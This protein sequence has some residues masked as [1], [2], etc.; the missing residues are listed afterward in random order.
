[1][2]L[3]EYIDI[4]H[5]GSQIRFAEFLGVNAQQVCLWSRLG[6][7]MIDGWMYSPRREI[8]QK[9]QLEEVKRKTYLNLPD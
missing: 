6:Y 8:P 7:I 2:K 5:G 3:K 4:H 1:M 9:V